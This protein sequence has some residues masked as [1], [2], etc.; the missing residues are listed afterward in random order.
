MQ[1]TIKMRRIRLMDDIKRPPKQ[2]LDGAADKPET[3]SSFSGPMNKQSSDLDPTDSK[4]EIGGLDKTTTD[5]LAEPDTTAPLNSSPVSLE[6]LDTGLDSKPSPDVTAKDKPMPDPFT[7][8]EDQDS[9]R[10]QAP[11]N[12]VGNTP[13]LP[14]EK[15]SEDVKIP[16]NTKESEPSSSSS[17]AVDS[18]PHVYDPGANNS[19]IPTQIDASNEANKPNEQVVPEAD[20]PKEAVAA[21]DESSKPGVTEAVAGAAS[22]GM[23]AKPDTQPESP[24]KPAQPETDNMHIPDAPDLSEHRADLVDGK[25]ETKT[26]SIPVSELPPAPDL[27]DGKKGKVSKAPTDHPKKKVNWIVILIAFLL[28]LALAGGAGYAYWQKSKEDSKTP[29]VT[30]PAEQTDDASKDISAEDITN[31]T[32]EIDKTLKQVEDTEEAV[33][34]DLTDTGL[35]L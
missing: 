22:A 33:N 1:L 2:Y 31:T 8:P 19:D 4:L 25:L 15:P 10:T 32:D 12:S 14:V 9:T 7:L 24:A 30:Q 11:D 21:K 5:S 16:V 27:S 13:E 20:K 3:P 29:A 17:T 18:S 28:A 34:S 35:G 6:D 23:A 26:G